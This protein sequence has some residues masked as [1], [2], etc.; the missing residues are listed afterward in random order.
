MSEDFA[1]MLNEH[2]GNGWVHAMGLVIKSATVDEVVGEWVI[3]D[4]HRQAYGIVHGGV[5]TGMI[6][7]L[8]SIGAHLV[9]QAR[10]QRAVGLDNHTSFIRAV[11]EG[12]L[13]G[14]ATPV[15]RGRTTQVWET[16]IYDAEHKLV[17]RGTVRLL[18]IAED[19]AL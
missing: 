8:S 1:K 18:C 15:T 13:R 17:A 10:G 16:S 3:G 11:R 4:Q 14:V 7:S 19:A 6:E 9:A 12:T 5:H 2:P